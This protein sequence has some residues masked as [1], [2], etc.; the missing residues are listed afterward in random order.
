MEE[1]FFLALAIVAAILVTALLLA[2]IIVKF[3]EWL[4]K[5]RKK[6]FN[7]R[8]WYCVISSYN[9]ASV[10][11]SWGNRQM[12]IQAENEEEAIQK[13]KEILEIQNEREAKDLGNSLHEYYNFQAFKI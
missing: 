11:Q 3:S 13:V 9:P 4:E 10:C 8:V 6:L 12:D 5:R 2:L 1:H 7:F